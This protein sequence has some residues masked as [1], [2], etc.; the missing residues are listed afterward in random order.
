M[1]EAEAAELALR[2]NQY[3]LNDGG[4]GWGWGVR[5]QRWWVGWGEYDLNGGGWGGS[6]G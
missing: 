6:G 1:N 5:P 4:R 2:F 3:D